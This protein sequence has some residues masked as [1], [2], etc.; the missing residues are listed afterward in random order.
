M[1]C[2]PFF[3]NRCRGKGNVMTEM[4]LQF[5]GWAECLFRPSR[6]KVIPG[7]RGSGKSWAVARA[8][9]LK[10]AERKLRIL[11]TREFQNSI[12]ESCHELLSSQIRAMGLAHK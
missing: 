6:Y 2:P 4:S 9:L 3:T 5:P 8:L 7:G 10:A 11:C 12:S 1:P